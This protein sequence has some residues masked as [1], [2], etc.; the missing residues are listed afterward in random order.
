MFPKSSSK[1]FPQVFN[2]T[3][4]SFF[5]SLPSF[6]FFLFFLFV[7]QLP[8]LFPPGKGYFASPARFF[9]YCHCFCYFRLWLCVFSLVQLRRG[10]PAA[11]CT[12]STFNSFLGR[13]INRA[14]N[15]PIY[16]T[17][18]VNPLVL[19]GGR[20]SMFYSVFKSPWTAFHGSFVL[21]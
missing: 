12:I 20:W 6:S 2:S 15:N 14:A 9:V 1:A 4:F 3:S 19:L 16:R 18:D 5:V 11:N 7:P 8:A 13:L 21:V 17:A 10:S